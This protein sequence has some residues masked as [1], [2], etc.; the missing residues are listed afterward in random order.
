MIRIEIKCRLRI[1]FKQNYPKKRLPFRDSAAGG[2]RI[3]FGLG[4][5]SRRAFLKL[6]AAITGTG[7]A[8]GTGLL[9]LGTKA[10]PKVIKEAEVIARGA[11]ACLLMLWT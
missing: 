7:A 8:A 10:A 3:G 4:S 1:T 5:M 6:M 11:M 2:G 9:K